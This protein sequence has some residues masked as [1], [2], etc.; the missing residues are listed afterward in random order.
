MTLDFD[1]YAVLGVPRDATGLQLAHA[2]HRLVR[3]YHP[4]VN[5]APDA[6]ARFDQVQRAFRLLSDPAARAEYDRAHGQPGA[7]GGRKG[8]G[9]ATGAAHRFS[10][11]PN[12]VNFGV[13]ER[14][15]P[16]ADRD[17]VVYWTGAP[18]RRVTSEPG[19]AWWTVLRVGTLGSSGVVF[20]LRAQAPAGA[21]SGRQQSEL[22]IMLDDTSIAVPLTA[23]IRNRPPSGSE[24]LTPVNWRTFRSGNPDW[25][26][27]VL[28]LAAFLFVL[29][30]SLAGS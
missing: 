5:P 13:I 6:A 23:E 29:V 16:G 26:F 25:V 4:D 8:A 21:A 7:A 10:T 1:P 17:V 19:T 30:M 11:D 2:R 12:T 28:L 24:P 15:K 3:Q 14:E 22:T 18:P 20:H 9:Q 27:P